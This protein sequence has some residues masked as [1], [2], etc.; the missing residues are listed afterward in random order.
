[1]SRLRRSRWSNPRNTL[2][3][4]TTKGAEPNAG[5][6]QM[7]AT[8]TTVGRTKGRRGLE[9]KNVRGTG[10]SP[11]IGQAIAVRFAEYGSNVAINY[12]R[13]PEEA[14]ETET[15][16]RACIDKVQREGVKDLL[17]QG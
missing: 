5:G 4:Q 14:R 12:L 1:M 13:E 11:G 8:T 15:Q 16:V 9:G 7:T 3:V 17:V 2:G 6:R 10:G